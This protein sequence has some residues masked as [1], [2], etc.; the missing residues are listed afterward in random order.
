MNCFR[1]GYCYTLLFRYTLLFGLI[2]MLSFTVLLLCFLNIVHSFHLFSMK[3][4]PT[5][6]HI[7]MK[8]SNKRPDFVES[9]GVVRV[10]TSLAGHEERAHK[11]G[12]IR[13]QVEVDVHATYLPLDTGMRISRILVASTT[14]F[15]VMMKLGHAKSLTSIMHIALIRHRQQC[16]L[17]EYDRLPSTSA[18]VCNGWSYEAQVGSPMRRKSR[19]PVS[20]LWV[21]EEESFQ[22][23]EVEIGSW[24]LASFKGN[25][26]NRMSALFSRDSSRVHRDAQAVSLVRPGF[27]TVKLLYVDGMIQWVMTFIEIENRDELGIPI[28][29]K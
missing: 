16:K 27:S 25:D 6:S 13:G 18:Q 2:S 15:D 29:R 17:M 9:D 11:K 22:S 8:T 20:A 14:N 28:G 5:T 23:F 21:I 26:S 19:T 3:S 12:K 10:L 7:I 24:L 4:T 1:T